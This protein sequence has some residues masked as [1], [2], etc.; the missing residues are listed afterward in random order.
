MN[1]YSNEY[2]Q[3]PSS[4]AAQYGKM[5]SAIC[6]RMLQN[7]EI[8]EDAAQEVWLE[9]IKS[10][11][12]F[13]NR[14]K[15]STWIYT[16][17]HRV[18]L[19]YA[20]HERLYSTRFLK[21][22]FHGEDREPPLAIDY[23]HTLWVKQMCDKCLTGVLHCLDNEARIAYIFR[24]VAGLSYPEITA[25][26][27]KEEFAVRQIISR[28]RRKLKNFLNDECLLYNSNGNC[29]CRMR[30]MALKVNLPI[31]YEKLRNSIKQIYFFRNSEKVMP[32]PNYWEKYL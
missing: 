11:S 5:V 22:Y 15:I 19:R 10:Y 32:G 31:E 20:A 16:I 4:I 18:V 8:A 7:N 30:K 17:T 29:R 25:V 26:L 1:K 3:L 2:K 14:S 6:R 28:S 27:G 9:V 13:D 24:D 21:S 23:D 12:Q